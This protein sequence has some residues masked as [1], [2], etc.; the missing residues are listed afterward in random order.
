MQR[1]NLGSQ[2][3]A[4]AKAATV[5][6]SV[7]QARVLRIVKRDELRFAVAA[8][9]QALHVDTR[10]RLVEVELR[11]LAPVRARDDAKI[12]RFQKTVA[13]RA[14]AQARRF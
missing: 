10:A 6:Q 4:L 14:V 9:A 12:T 13:K 7:S 2:T 8:G 1:K 11:P 5:V 3:S